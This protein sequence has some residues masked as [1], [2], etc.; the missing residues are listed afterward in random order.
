MSDETDNM[1]YA[2]AIAIGGDATIKQRQRNAALYRRLRDGDGT[3]DFKSSGLASFT[4]EVPF[5][6]C[7]YGGNPPSI[8]F[9]LDKA[10]DCLQ[11]LLHVISDHFDTR[12]DADDEVERL[13]AALDYLKYKV[14]GYDTTKELADE[15]VAGTAKP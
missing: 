8:T 14:D 9:R 13:R 12:C 15:I 10:S 2:P 5:A 3:G 11:R 1:H 7:S 6:S 4:F